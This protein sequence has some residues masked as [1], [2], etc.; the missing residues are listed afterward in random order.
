QSRGRWAEPFAMLPLPRTAL[1]LGLGTIGSEIAR[2]L[3]GLGLHVR[4]CARSATPAQRHACDEFV[5]SAHWRDLLGATDLLM[6]ALPL[7][8]TTRGCIGTREFAAMPPHA[9]VVNV[10]RDAVIERAALVAA[11][12]EARIGAAALDV[13]DPV[14]PSDDPLWTTP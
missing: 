11:L 13:L 6:L 14:P 3:R 2:L 12:R 7:D 1:V 9:I 10:A 5:D 8:A 4:G